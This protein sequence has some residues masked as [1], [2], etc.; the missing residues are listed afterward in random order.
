MRTIPYDTG[1]VKI[2]CNYHP[3]PNP[4]IMSRTEVMIQNALL[5][6]PRRIDWSGIGITAVCVGV[7]VLAYAVGWLAA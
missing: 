7:V 4:P 5:R 3:K 1:R 6:G 2:G